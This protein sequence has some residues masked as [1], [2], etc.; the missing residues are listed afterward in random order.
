[1]AFSVLNIE[2]IPR[3]SSCLP[4]SLELGSESKTL[5]T[6]LEWGAQLAR[7]DILS[8]DTRHTKQPLQQALLPLPCPM[9]PLQVLAPT[10]EQSDQLGQQ[11]FPTQEP[12]AIPRPT[13]YIPQGSPVS[14]RE[15]PQQ[16]NVLTGLS[17]SHCSLSFMWG[18]MG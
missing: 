3:R 14:W 13:P 7:S 2:L 18:L 12:L 6:P 10:T 8:V 11:N 17:M 15:H 1:M 9:S 16:D 4:R 5:T